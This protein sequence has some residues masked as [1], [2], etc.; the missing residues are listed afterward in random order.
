MS[1]YLRPEITY[2]RPD[3]VILRIGIT[4]SRS[5]SVNLRPGRSCEAMA[6]EMANT[7]EKAYSRTRMVIVRSWRVHLRRGKAIRGKGW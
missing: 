5:G 2:L 6:Y 4:I 3:M 7:F 1:S